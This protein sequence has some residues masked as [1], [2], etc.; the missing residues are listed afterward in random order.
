M[1]LTPAILTLLLLSATVWPQT[2]PGTEQQSSYEGQKVGSIEIAANPRINPD[3]YRPLI[4]QK[5]GEPYSEKDIKA[6][7]QALEDTQAFAKVEVKVAADP[8]GLK[9]TFVLEPAYYIGLISF[10]G[11]MKR[12][13]YARL[14]QT[15]DLLSLSLKALIDLDIEVWFP[16]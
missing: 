7:I 13:S 11:A 14:L 6:S 3:Q 15:V 16:S 12:F 4:V 2:N 1:R 9:L 10:P 5:P 8:A